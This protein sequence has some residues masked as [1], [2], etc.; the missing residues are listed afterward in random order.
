V[1][2]RAYGDHSFTKATIDNAL[3]AI[4]LTD[5]RELVLTPGTWAIN[6]NTD[7]SAYTN[8]TFKI[9]PGAVISHGVFTVKLPNPCAGDY[10]IFS[11]AGAVTFYGA[12]PYVTPDWWGVDGV[13]DTLA[14][15]AAFTSGRTVKFTRSYAVTETTISAMGQT[16]DFNGYSLTG[17]HT[18]AALSAP[19]NIT[20]AYLTLK[21]INVDANYKDYNSVVHWYSVLGGAYPAQWNK[22]YGMVLNGG[23]MGLLYGIYP[24]GAVPSEAQSENT[25]YSFTTRNTQIPFVGNQTN[26]FL[27][28]V[29]PILDCY[30][31]EWSLQPGYD[32]TTYNTAARVFKNLAGSLTIFGGELLKQGT[33]LGYGIEGLGFDIYGTYLEIAA[34]QFY[35]TGSAKLA[36]VTSYFSNDHSVLFT[37]DK[38][39]TG[40][41]T[42]SGNTFIRP[43]GTD[44]YSGA[45]ITASSDASDISSVFTVDVHN[46]KF[47]EWGSNR[48]YF[49]IVSAYNKWSN[50]NLRLYNTT[51]DTNAPS[52]EVVESHNPKLSI[53]IP[54]SF[55]TGEQTATKI[56]FPET[57]TITGIRGIVMKA[58]AATD[59]GTI[60]GSNAT[61]ASANGVIT[62][63]A[64]ATLNTEYSVS[65]STNNVVLKGGAYTLTSAKTTVGGKVLVTLEYRKGN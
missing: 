57:V 42:L 28:L 1:D 36:D 6:D 45:T 12:M 35:L 30:P 31:Y 5:K 17:I 41:L 24:G 52:N 60:T 64:S 15:Q 18:G 48:E 19:L 33:Q 54:M 4:G 46:S 44:S 40:K 62:A 25:I 47:T 10:Q 8:V 2:V 51:F 13:D 61:G 26:G 9:V 14:V 50:I 37:I 56:Y 55:E 23:V 16:I 22:V 38:S 59:S 63:L 65:P 20:G 58:L 27:T 53:A 34:A 43:A 11:G 7:W 3:A 39:A 29:A 49:N 32:A 21:N